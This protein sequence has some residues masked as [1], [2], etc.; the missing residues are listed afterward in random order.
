ME[1]TLLGFLKLKDGLREVIR[2]VQI[3][4][5]DGSSGASK[6][7]DKVLERL[8][9]PLVV[10][11][12]FN[13]RHALSADNVLRMSS[14]G[15]D[16]PGVILTYHESVEV[17]LGELFKQLGD[18]DALVDARL[19][20]RVVEEIDQKRVEELID[21]GQEIWVTE[22]SVGGVAKFLV[23]IK[24]QLEPSD[25]FFLCSDDSLDHLILLILAVDQL[26]DSGADCLPALP[27]NHVKGLLVSLKGSEVPV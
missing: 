21:L 18:V 22:G 2:P 19:Y 16:Q 27:R 10:E 8:L 5:S 9:G 26:F 7:L 17:L 11:L 12:P 1:G 6:A 20:V 14:S 3:P 25:A 24:A 15:D 13:S 23:E 4:Y